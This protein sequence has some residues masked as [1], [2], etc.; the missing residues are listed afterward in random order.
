M[1]T[2]IIQG[3][4]KSDG[5]TSKVINY[6]NN[7]NQFDVIDLKIKNIGPFDYDFSNSDDDF[8]P[9]IEEIINKYDTI[10]LATPV[11]WYSMSGILKNFLDRFSD[12]L[13]YKKELGRKLRGKNLAMI[14]NSGDN[15]LKN[16][17]T[18]PFIESANY[19]GMNYLGDT[20]AWFI[21]DEIASDAKKLMDDFM[22]KF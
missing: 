12:L 17:F 11:Y 14:S 3:S 20:H 4:S 8:L 19:L 15:D 1:K 7:K 21:N 16:G 13:D 10:I 18:M 6:L 5:N 22:K 2:V 9:L